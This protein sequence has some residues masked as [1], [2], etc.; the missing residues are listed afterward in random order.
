MYFKI[1][2]KS[3]PVINEEGDNIIGTLLR[4]VNELLA[5][6]ELEKRVT[7]LER[8]L[9]QQLEAG[10]ILDRLTKPEQNTRFISVTTTATQTE[11]C[12]TERRVLSSA[13][14]IDDTSSELLRN[15]QSYLSFLAAPHSPAQRRHSRSNSITMR[16]RS[17]SKISRRSR[18]S[19]GIGLSFEY[20]DAQGLHDL[21]EEPITSTPK[22]VQEPPAV[23]TAISTEVEPTDSQRMT[24]VQAVLWAM[25][26]LILAMKSLES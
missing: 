6:P 11:T 20:E 26:D 15:L 10:P 21:Q 24:Q 14:S 4:D 5:K 7:E 22:K 8:Q 12:E 19:S 1:L 23:P 9:Q 13:V 16:K 25:E 2:Q 17:D 18:S 3:I